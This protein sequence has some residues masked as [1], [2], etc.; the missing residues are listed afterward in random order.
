MDM[1][2]QQHSRERLGN[3]MAAVPTNLKTK[4]LTD[5]AFA[6]D[7]YILEK[8]SS[9]KLMQEIQILEARQKRE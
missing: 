3:T 6:S 1:Y 5:L 7:A 4:K 8:K 9:T 2:G